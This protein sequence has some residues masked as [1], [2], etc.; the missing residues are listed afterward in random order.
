M[1]SLDYSILFRSRRCCTGAVRFHPCPAL[2]YVT[3][4]VTQ[5]P[6]SLTSTWTQPKATL[7]R[8]HD[9][10]KTEARLSPS[11]ASSNIPAKDSVSP[12]ALALTGRPTPSAPSAGPD[13]TGLQSPRCCQ[14]PSLRE[15]AA[16]R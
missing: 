14:P 15:V 13:E 7:V 2:L 9:G 1:L 16:S 10:R 4:W 8:R 6:H 3:G 12:D 11:P 5:L